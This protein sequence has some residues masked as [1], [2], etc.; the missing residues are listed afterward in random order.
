MDDAQS[1]SAM[2]R[3]SLQYEQYSTTSFVPTI[4]EH[5]DRAAD[6]ESVATLADRWSGICSE[7]AEHVY[8]EYQRKPVST[9][10]SSDYMHGVTAMIIGLRAKMGAQE[11]IS[12]LQRLRALCKETMSSNQ[13][14]LHNKVSPQVSFGACAA[15]YFPADAEDVANDSSLLRTSPM[16]YFYRVEGLH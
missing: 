3:S 8:A 5:L 9:P 6:A 1:L 14:A 2:Y 4:I 13:A 16:T 11:I 15:G 7:I 10:I 12:R